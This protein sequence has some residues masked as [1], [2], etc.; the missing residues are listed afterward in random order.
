MKISR[1]PNAFTFIEVLIGISI[2]SI[3]AVLGFGYYKN[4]FTE[5]ELDSTSKRIA[6]DLK[7]A[8]TKALSGEDNKN[9]GVH[10]V[11]GT[12]DYYEIFN[13]P[14]DFSDASATTTE[15]IYLTGGLTFY[16]PIEGASST[17]VFSKINATTTSSTI[18]ILSGNQSSTITI[19]AFGV[20]Y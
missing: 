19:G 1:R 16:S 9:W 15:T 20:V 17:V 4:F 18:S 13:T 12:D 14:T 7:N 3:A 11:N 2:I 6:S 8:R 10:F 5:V